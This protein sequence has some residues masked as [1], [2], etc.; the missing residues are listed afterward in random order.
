MIK[1]DKIFSLSLSMTHHRKLMK[2]SHKVLTSETQ[3]FSYPS[4]PQGGR[5]AWVPKRSDESVGEGEGVLPRSQFKMGLPLAILLGLFIFSSPSSLAEPPKGLKDGIAAIVNTEVITISELETELRDETIR[6]RARYDGEELERRLTHKEYDVINRIIERKLQLQEARAKGI[7]I[8]EKELDQALDQIRQ[9][10]PTIADSTPPSRLREELI[11]RRML[12]F[13]VRRRL[14]VSPEE[15]RSYY[16]T[17]Q[18]EFTTPGQYHLRQILL[19]PQDGESN[20]DVWVRAETLV[21]QLQDGTDFSE[22]AQEHS[23][24]TESI[25]GG[26]LG[27]MRKNELLG[28]LARAL[29]GM[30][31]GDVSQPVETELGIHI[32]TL[33]EITPGEPLPFDEVKDAIKSKLFQQ[34]TRDVREEWLSNLK[35]KAYIEIKF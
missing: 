22:L 8:S 30:N 6:L 12:D 23:E 27:F 15:V 4:P 11:L 35:D 16:T 33:E 24:G 5:P 1:L 9:S 13:E 21:Q 3:A 26:D 31:I 20:T 14:M 18:E 28:P 7:T 29:E 2:P 25:L 34:K 17:A 32:L 19:K 10:Q